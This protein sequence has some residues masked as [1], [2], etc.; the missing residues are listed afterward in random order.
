[1]WL[2]HFPYPTYKYFPKTPSFMVKT[3]VSPN[4]VGQ[5]NPMGQ[6]NPMDRKS[7]SQYRFAVHY[8]YIDCSWVYDLYLASRIRSY[9]RDDTFN[10]PRLD[11]TECNQPVKMLTCISQLMNKRLGTKHSSSFKSSSLLWFMI[12]HMVPEQQYI[13]ECWS[14]I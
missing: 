10:Y 6:D 2:D 11:M 5:N 13:V 8:S 14:K 7:M 3:Q 4:P 9:I 12:S 1:M